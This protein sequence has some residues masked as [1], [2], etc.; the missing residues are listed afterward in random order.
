[1][2]RTIFTEKCLTLKTVTV[3]VKSLAPKTPDLESR[4]QINI[5]SAHCIQ[6]ALLI[7]CLDIVG[8]MM[9]DSW[10]KNVNK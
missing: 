9:I 3:P 2:Y 8:R 4:H 5:M 10:P 6:S 7:C 1:M